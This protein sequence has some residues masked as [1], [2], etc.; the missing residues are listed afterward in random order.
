MLG[1][2]DAEDFSSCRVLRSCP[3]MHPDPAEVCPPEVAPGVSQRALRR[4]WR[5]RTEAST[6]R[7]GKPDSTEQQ[8]IRRRHRL[9]NGLAYREPHNGSQP[10]SSIG[11]CRGQD[12]PTR[13]PA[14]GR[15]CRK[16][17]IRPIAVPPPARG[18]AEPAEAMQAAHRRLFCTFWVYQKRRRPN[19]GDGAAR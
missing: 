7:G 6:Y 9:C 15:L 4:S 5:W 3:I 13:L 1:Q 18:S 8:R 11:K 12:R 10:D 16:G 2:G 19:A 17:L 14:T